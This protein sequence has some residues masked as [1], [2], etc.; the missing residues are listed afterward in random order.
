MALVLHLMLIIWLA[1]ILLMP[2]VAILSLYFSLFHYLMFGLMVLFKVS[3]SMLDFLLLKFWK[4]YMIH[5]LYLKQQLQGRENS[6]LW[7]QDHG[8]KSTEVLFQKQVAHPQHKANL[9]C[10]VF[11]RGDDEWPFLAPGDAQCQ[12]QCWVPPAFTSQVL[13][14]HV[15][16]QQTKTSSL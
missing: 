3:H 4:R 1:C 13:F 12:Q 9:V 14:P 15:A 10:S 11:S 2:L 5:Y 16:P 7:L 6:L 8:I